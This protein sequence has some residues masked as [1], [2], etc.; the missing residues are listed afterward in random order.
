MTV[1]TWKDNPEFK[2][3]MWVRGTKPLTQ[4]ITPKKA[5]PKTKKTKLTN[6]LDPVHLNGSGIKNGKHTKTNLVPKR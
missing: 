1:E 3:E 2:Y 5:K 6:R 4:K